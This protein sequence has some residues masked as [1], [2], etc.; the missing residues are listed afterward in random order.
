MQYIYTTLLLHETKQE[1]SEE[2]IKKVL[3]AAGSSVDEAKIKALVASLADVNID[4]AI[5]EAA[6][7]PSA[8]AP[9]SEHKKEEKKEEPKVDENKAAA[10]LGSLFG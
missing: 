1:V 10:G 7:M 4:E 9:V 2:R 5:K 6:V 8:G 3:S